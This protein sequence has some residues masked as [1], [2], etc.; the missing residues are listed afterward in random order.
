V[1]GAEFKRRVP[2]WRRT[3]RSSVEDPFRYVQK[4]I[5]GDLSDRPHVALITVVQ[6]EGRARDFILYRL[7]EETDSRV[8][9]GDKHAEQDKVSMI[10]TGIMYGAGADTVSPTP[11]QSIEDGALT[12][13]APPERV[14]ARVILASDDSVPGSPA[15]CTR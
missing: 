11:Y 12:P 7:L 6:A 15:P 5:V 8:V 9:G 4:N 13:G 10:T 14:G 1:P 3:G 2:D